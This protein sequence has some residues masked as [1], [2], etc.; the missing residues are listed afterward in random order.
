[1]DYQRQVAELKERKY[2]Q[3][4]LDQLV[5]NAHFQTERLRIEGDKY[6]VTYALRLRYLDQMID[7]LAERLNG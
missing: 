2:Y 7:E 5:R 1:M 4:P 6:E 3:Y